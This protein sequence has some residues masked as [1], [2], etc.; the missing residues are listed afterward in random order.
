VPILG[1][2][3]GL[4]PAPIGRRETLADI[5]QTLSSRLALAPGLDGESW[6]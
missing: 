1:F 5:A 3:A 2:G 6:L 4:A